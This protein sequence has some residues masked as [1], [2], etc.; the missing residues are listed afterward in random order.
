MLVQLGLN[1]GTQLL[2]HTFTWSIASH[3][4]VFL[5]Q[6]FPLVCQCL[7]LSWVIESKLSELSVQ[8]KNK[9]Q[10][11]GQGSKLASLNLESITLI[12]KPLSRPAV[13][14]LKLY[15]VKVSTLSLYVPQLLLQSVH[16]QSFGTLR[17]GH[18]CISILLQDFV[19]SN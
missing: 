17:P 4:P 5:F 10:C 11:A 16:T 18:F 14:Y 6:L 7:C 8:F 3:L 9:V 19:K 1:T 2:Q 13:I 15:V 12:M